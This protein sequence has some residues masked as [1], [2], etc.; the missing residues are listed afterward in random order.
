MK[1][2]LVSVS[3]GAALMA[4]A[5]NA[6]ILYDNFGPGQSYDSGSA[7]AIVGTDEF[8]GLNDPAYSFTTTTSASLTE[9]DIALFGSDPVA[10]EVTTAVPFSGG[11]DIQPGSV[12]GSWTVT[13]N[14]NFGQVTDITGISNVTLTAGTTYFLQAVPGTSTTFDGWYGNSTDASSVLWQCSGS[15][16]TYTACVQHYSYPDVS[17]GAFELQGSPLVSAAPEPSSWALMIA[18]VAMVG[19][20]MRY[21]GRR[22]GFTM[23]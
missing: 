7:R 22:P 18:G 21:R 6:A 9:V 1:V 14:S 17:D 16:S 11:A 20:M 23:A 12:L 3:L 15:N 8:S 2:L 13:P 5:A 4:T 10:V 19:G